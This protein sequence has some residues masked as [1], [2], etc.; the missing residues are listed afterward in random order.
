[1]FKV[2]VWEFSLWITEAYTGL[3]FMVGDFANAFLSLE[4]VIKFSYLFVGFRPA[5][6]QYVCCTRRP[7]N[8]SA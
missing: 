4:V 6:R 3:L 5:E 7:T 2:S 1:M 8:G